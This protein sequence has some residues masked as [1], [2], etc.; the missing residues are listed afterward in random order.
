MLELTERERLI[1]SRALFVFWREYRKSDSGKV[2]GLQIDPGE[3][4]IL[5]IKIEELNEKSSVNF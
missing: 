1:I 5:M 3:I 2:E 4:Q